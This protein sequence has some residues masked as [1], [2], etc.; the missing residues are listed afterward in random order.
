MA[1]KRGTAKAM[2]PVADT[3]KGTC[4]DCKHSYDWHNKGADGSLILCRCPYHKW[5][6]FLSSDYCENFKSR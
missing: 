1:T 3:P 5:C 2:R 6:K 4:K